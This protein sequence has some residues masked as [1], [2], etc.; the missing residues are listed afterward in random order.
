MSARDCICGQHDEPTPPARDWVLA[1]VYDRGPGHFYR[2]QV[3]GIN[4]NFPPCHPSHTFTW[5][6]PNIDDERYDKAKVV[7]V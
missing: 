3:S 4:L 7:H 5:S 2:Y 1:A 6:V